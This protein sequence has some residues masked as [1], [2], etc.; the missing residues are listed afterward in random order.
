MGEAKRRR[1]SGGVPENLAEKLVSDY[2]GDTWDEQGD[3]LERILV[4]P[5]P[6]RILERALGLVPDEEK[7]EFSEFLFKSASNV[8]GHSVPQKNGDTLAAQL[9][10]FA[11]PVRGPLSHIEKLLEPE[12]FDEFTRLI[13]IAGVSHDRSNVILCPV[14]LDMMSA[15][16][17]MPPNIR[18]MGEALLVALNHEGNDPRPSE[19]LEKMLL[20]SFQKVPQNSIL[21]VN[22]IL[23][24]ARLVFEDAS[25]EFPQDNFGTPNYG[26]D[27][28]TN[29]RLVDAFLD[30]SESAEQQFVQL[31]TEMF[32]EMELVLEIEAP[33][34]WTKALGESALARL[35]GDLMLESAIEGK[36]LSDTA[37]LHFHPDA[38]EGEFSI[39]AVDGG[40]IYGP[41]KVPLVMANY[42]MDSILNWMETEFED[43]IPHP[44]A[45]TL[46][47]ARRR[48]LAH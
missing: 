4:N 41:V 40:D 26:D 37:R 48:R 3:V 12:A 31:A 21:V 5:R 20:P 28:E 46:P 11:I 2:M 10:V 23:M 16:D 43:I 36:T 34:G 24:G 39:V 14:A 22:R 38:E 35:K 25:G 45:D 33:M 47:S 30:A 27:D 18:Q 19:M 8:Y 44:T 9:S 13:R 6:M 29:E 15:T 32:D 42:G 7:T 1:Q 17:M